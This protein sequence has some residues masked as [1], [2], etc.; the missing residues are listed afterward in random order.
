MSSENPP[1]FP[2]FRWDGY[3]WI[4]S[5]PL[6]S[7]KG[8]QAGNGPYGALSGDGEADGLVQIVFA[9]E[10]RDD[11]PLTA[12][13]IELVR[14]VIDNEQSVHDALMARLLAEYPSLREDVLDDY[15]E[16]EAAEL[17]PPATTVD[18]L[19]KLCG[20]VSINVHQLVKSGKP[21]I[22]D[23]L[24]CT[25]D[26]EHGAGVLLHGDTALECGGADT[27]ILFWLA[28]QYAEG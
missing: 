6:P 22:G 16:D 24:G 12:D 28:A 27:A 20:I 18:E 2:Q 17:L 1:L 4:S 23:E 5:A 19:K 25:W 15:D 11:S 7:W 14:W 21:F 3:Y 13:E 26:E 10:G 8:F 9:P